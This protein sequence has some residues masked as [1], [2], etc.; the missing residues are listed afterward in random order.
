MSKRIY[1]GNLPWSVTFEKLKELFSSFGEIEEAL[2]I[3]DKYTG[4]S[5]GFGFV[6]FK[7]NSDADKAIGE[8][9]EKEIEGR[10]FV[11][12]EARPLEKKTGEGEEKAARFGEENNE[13]KIPKE[14]HYR[15]R[16]KHEK[17]EESGEEF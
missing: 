14:K 5:R 3:A 9:N 8:M 16:K 1:V 17:H 12:K 6:T 10:N 15:G 2:V 13:G 11:V 4:R 7:K